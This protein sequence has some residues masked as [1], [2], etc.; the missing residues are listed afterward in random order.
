M[1]LAQLGNEYFRLVKMDNWITKNS[2]SKALGKGGR[3]KL[4]RAMKVGIVRSYKRNPDKRTG[5]VMVN[6]D[7][8]MKIKDKAI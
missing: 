8:L 6:F 1:R 2:A 3:G 7:D 4:E 5:R